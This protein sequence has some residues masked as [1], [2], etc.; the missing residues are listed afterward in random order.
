MAGV[1]VGANC[2]VQNSV[3][4]T[5][6]RLGDGCSVKDCSLGPGYCVPAGA[7]LDEELLGGDA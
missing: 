2:H 3:L 6:C 5:G 1:D 4:S 7:E